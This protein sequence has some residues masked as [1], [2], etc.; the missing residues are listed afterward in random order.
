V[1]QRL[2]SAS[3]APQGEGL[4]HLAFHAFH[5][6]A[7]EPA[8]TYCRRAGERAYRRSSNAE[9]VEYFHQALTCLEH[10][11]ET[12][13]RLG[14][15]VD[16]LFGLRWALWPLGR[17]TEMREALRD[18]DRRAE[19]LGDLRRQ[20][21]VAAYLTDY[22]WATADNAA[23]LETGSRALSIAERVGDDILAG[24][25]RFGLGLARSALGQYREAAEIVAQAVGPKA[26]G[27]P[28]QQRRVTV[29]AKAYLSRYLAETGDFAQGLAYA[30]SGLETAELAGDSFA[31]LASL[32]GLGTL[33]LR[34]AAL[35]AAIA[36]LSRGLEIARSRGLL[37]F[38]P[39]LGS[40]LGFAYAS[41]GKASEG[42]GLLDQA[43]AAAERSGIPASQALWMA[44]AAEAH[45]LAGRPASARN[46]AE[47]AL[48]LARDRGE[49]GH[50]GWALRALSTAL[51]QSEPRELARA[52]ELVQAAVTRAEALGM[53][54][55]TVRCH[56]DLFRLFEGLGRPDDAL[57]AYDAG[58]R[59]WAELN[60]AGEPGVLGP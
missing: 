46:L 36:T 31:L 6:E 47:R 41:S 59:L 26:D 23:A 7:W 49:R 32:L 3:P 25:A 22:F 2:E 19:R 42:L 8:L 54:P 45:A 12:D 56:F 29:M 27:P 30:E 48:E 20:G 13:E 43:L 15:A 17:L 28:D 53:R 39:S 4:D 11:P 34:R 33:H 40:S 57:G 58:V 44:Y 10:L 5:G 24:Q 16:V 60:M 1:L 18:A 38:V 55:L 37:N 14:H 21:M 51:M 52:T 9:A 35:P 50:E